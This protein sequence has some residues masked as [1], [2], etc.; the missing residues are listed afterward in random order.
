[1]NKRYTYLLAF[2]KETQRPVK[3]INQ[4]PVKLVLYRVWVGLKVNAG[5]NDTL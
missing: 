1:M 4:E 2:A 5:G 3:K